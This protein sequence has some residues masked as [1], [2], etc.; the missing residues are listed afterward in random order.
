MTDIQQQIQAQR[1]QISQQQSQLA[2]A[3]QQVL[4][5]QQELR[6][7]S[8]ALGKMGALMKK[9]AFGK[10]VSP[11]EKAQKQLNIQQQNIVKEKNKI[12][13]NLKE[14]LKNISKQ[15]EQLQKSYIKSAQEGNVG[16][17]EGITIQDKGLIQRQKVKRTQLIQ[18]TK[19]FADY[20]GLNANLSIMK[21]QLK[22]IFTDTE[23]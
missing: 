16:V 3:R 7:T 22:N 8:G 12:S 17:A 10:R 11:Y 21:K 1:S 14:E 20:F 6:G 9:I 13:S 19:F 5:T 18:T 2:Q 4:P 23:K 15:R